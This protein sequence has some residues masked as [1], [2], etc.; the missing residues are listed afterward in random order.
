MAGDKSLLPL[1]PDTAITS[2]HQCGFWNSA[3]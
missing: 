3:S 1:I 2:E